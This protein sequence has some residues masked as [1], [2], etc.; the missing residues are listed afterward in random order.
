MASR[1]IIF[2]I[3]VTILL[4]TT[5]VSIIALSNTQKSQ[6]ATTVKNLSIW[7]VGG[8]TEEYQTVFD[9][10]RATAPEYE[11]TTLD[12]RV[13]PDYHS[14]H[15]I[16]LSTL[17]DGGG[18]D[19]FMVEAWGDDILASKSAS[20]PSEYI[21][22]SAFDKHYEDIFLPLIESEWEGKSLKQ[23]LRWV[24]LG[25]ETLGVFYNKSYF[26]LLPKT[27]SEIEAL[28]GEST[29]RSFFPTNLGL[30][31]IYTPYAT[32]IISAFLISGKVQGTS[33]LDG[34]G[35][36]LSKYLAFRDLPIGGGDTSPETL[37]DLRDAMDSEALTTLDLF[38]R[39]KIAMV[40]G[41]PS[42]IREIEK[43]EKRAGADAVS[44]IILTERLPV[45]S[46]GK[47]TTS[48]A[49]YRYLALSDKTLYPIAGADFLSYLMS[50][51]ALLR[52]QEVFPYLISPQKHLSKT[53]GN[54]SL[55]KLFAR[56]RL[57]AFLPLPGEKLMI[58]E[59]GLKW[60]YEKIYRDYIDRNSKIDISN[61]LNRI[62]NIVECKTE[63]SKTATL[64]EKCLESDQL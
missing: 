23:S 14:Y 11:D 50:E 61:I 46:L 5:I 41:Y 42:L 44:D 40:I 10:F 37:A 9:G 13:F 28:Y 52:V 43:S 3:I 62:K 19:I 38:M 7:V 22:L 57:D 17:A 45:D 21:D 26:S 30:W 60:E 64:S 31:P 25:Y 2:L 20:I 47:N 51:R 24:P 39:G 63:S 8:T 15:D 6:K 35:S 27:W 16:L 12:I 54:T 56:A 4:V 48:L 18:P 58:F 33:G 53:Q 36:A 55:S 29:G 32:D 1:K 34:W 49:R 59:Y